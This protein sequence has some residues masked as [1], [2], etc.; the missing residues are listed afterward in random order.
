MRITT[1]IFI[2]ILFLQTSCTENLFST[3]ADKTSDDA[4]LYSAQ[5]YLDEADWDG[6]ISAISAL[7]T[8]ARATRT[9]REIIISAYAGKCGFDFITFVQALADMSGRFFPFLLQAFPDAGTEEYNACIAAETELKALQSTET[10]GQVDHLKFVFVSMAKMGSL[11]NYKMATAANVYDSAKD[12]CNTAHIS[13]DEVNQVVTGLALIV[14]NIA[15]AALDDFDASDITDVCATLV[16]AGLTNICAMV[17]TSAVTSSARCAMR[18][19]LNESS[20][21]GLGKCTG[22]IATCVCG[23]ACI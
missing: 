20:S 12:P 8:E 21:L 14:T 4:L 16:T 1:Y 6:A 9:A 15:D 18:S 23:G 13:N 22:D 10:L 11:L 3:T 2:L 5:R 7:D 19:I 17:N